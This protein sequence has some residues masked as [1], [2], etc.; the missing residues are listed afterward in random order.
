MDAV[1]APVVVFFSPAPVTHAAPAS[2][3]EYMAPAA[4][5]HAA[6]APVSSESRM[7]VP[8][9]TTLVT[10]FNVTTFVAF[11]TT[12]ERETCAGC[13]HGHAQGCLWMHTLSG[14]CTRKQF[15]SQPSR[16]NHRGL[17]AEMAEMFKRV[18]GA[19]FTSSITSC[20]LTD[21]KLMVTDLTHLQ[22]PPRLTLPVFFLATRHPADVDSAAGTQAL[23]MSSLMTWYAYLSVPALHC[24]V[25]FSPR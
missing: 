2:V 4:A 6:P 19:A 11:Q 23:T 24:R 13:S 12:A 7:F 5:G 1:P 22:L 10:T 3:V 8:R 21:T 16:E 18:K 9:C 20:A 15:F 17:L 25:P 14:W